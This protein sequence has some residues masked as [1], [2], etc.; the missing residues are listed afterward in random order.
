MGVSGVGRRHGADGLL[1]Y[2]EPQTIATTR[3]LNLGGP[4]G[5]PPK[6]WAKIMPPFVKALQYVP[7]R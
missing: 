6:V 4:R 2:T 7:G 5:L 1:K 3:I